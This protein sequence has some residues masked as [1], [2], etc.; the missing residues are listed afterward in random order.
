MVRQ[1]AR[2]AE[3]DDAATAR[4]RLAAMCAD[5]LPDPD[6]RARVEPRLAA[7]LGL[8]AAPPGSTEELTG[9]WRTLFERIAD[10]GTTVL[11]FEDLH[12]ADPGLLDF[13]EALLGGTRA[14]AILVI[15]L[16]RP[17]LIEAR[18]TWGATVRNHLRLDLAPLDADA[19]ELLL[20][21]LA[22]GIPQEAIAT[23]AARSAGIPL[24]AVETVRMLLDSGRLT[25][26]G[27][28]FRLA[29]DLRDLAVPDS[30]TSLLGARLDA[31]APDA[32]DVVGHASV[33][34]ISFEPA[35]LAAVAGRPEREVRDSLETL[36]RRELFA[37]DDDPRSPERG[38]YRFL[39]GVLRE[40][41]YGRL[42]RRERQARHLAAAELLASER[43][44]ELAG[45]VA[46]HYLE[47]V[48]NA[49]DEEREALRTR[50]LAALEGA[51]TRAAAIG[52]HASAASYLASALELAA[53]DD[54]GLRLRE[55]RV[56]ELFAAEPG[57]D[58]AREAAI[59]LD[60]SR[61]RGDLGLQARAACF[62]AGPMLSSGHPADAVRLLESTREALGPFVVEHPDG[63]RLL[64]ELGRCRLM[65]GQETGTL[66][67]ID[68]AL[69]VAERFEL[70]DVIGE[71]LAS[72]GWALGVTDRP[73]EAA[74]LLHGAI[75]HAEQHGLLRPEFRSRMNFSAWISLDDSRETF[76]VTRE[77]MEKARRLGLDAWVYPLAGNAID[78]AFELGEWD[79]IAA[80]VAEL[81]MEEQE[82]AWQAGGLG[83]L[84]L[85][86]VLRGDRARAAALEA[87]QRYLT[88]DHDD[89]QLTANL[90]AVN[91]C[92]T[93]IDG[94][95]DAAAAAADRLLGGIPFDR[96][97]DQMLNTLVG[98]LRRDP[99]RLR[100][101]T[102]ATGRAVLAARDVAGAALEVLQGDR[103]RFADVDDAID[104]LE[105]TE[106]H[107]SAAMFR[108]ARVLLA[109][110]DAGAPAS[111]RAAAAWFS[112]VGAVAALKGVEPF[113]EPDDTGSRRGL[114]QEVAAAEA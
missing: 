107:F 75:W 30:L 95:L 57:A 84:R 96:G 17:E 33:L 87:R 79:W 45:V 18:P 55:A 93:V 48:H 92:A 36:A 23:I 63:V 81:R 56:G 94:D 44:D 80:I 64:A 86:A 78:A 21:G 66:P 39:Q 25:E 89:P 3:S 40:V 14:R 22:P 59:L 62:A 46:T 12:W 13:I 35:V 41:A 60:A 51:A 4:E 37:L 61:A 82:I 16:A 34:G 50:A 111:A 108:R 27:G 72:K 2:I 103:S 42:S 73:R 109:P 98:L 65:A 10:R 76:S 101:T 43:G 15:V 24:Y 5:Y 49:S 29:G 54:E 9:A 32:R 67:I 88:A 53:D 11:V 69:V 68:E 52:A 70:V 113:L 105:A 7:L 99:A 6:E 58:V 102:V 31:L 100:W 20:V 90:E 106:H 110:D 71:L 77:G 19:M 38:R 74:A 26:H 91:V 8:E 104:R 83:Q 28:R 112:S 1:R 97:E 85:V 114:V 47:A